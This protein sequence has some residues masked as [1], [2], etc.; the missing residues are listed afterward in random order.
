MLYTNAR[1]FSDGLAPVANKKGLW[2]FIDKTGKEVIGFRF[3]YASSFTE[4]V[5]RVLMGT[6]WY[7]LDPGGNLSKLEQ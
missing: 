4:G 2:G 3:N 5:S 7:L 6:K 1:S